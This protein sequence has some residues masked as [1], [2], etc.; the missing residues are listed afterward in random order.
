LLYEAG[1]A[2]AFD[3]VLVV[4]ASESIRR[5][6]VAARGQDFVARSE[7]QMTEDDKIRRADRYLVNDGS[8]S[9]L[10]EWVAERFEEYRT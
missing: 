1:L 6:R 10:E 8:I 9:L 3:A 7:R 2:D 4:S 5:A